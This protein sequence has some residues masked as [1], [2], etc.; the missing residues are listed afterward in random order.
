[1]KKTDSRSDVERLHSEAETE[2]KGGKQR[3]SLK[4]RLLI[5]LAAVVLIPSGLILYNE[6]LPLQLDG[7]KEITIQV[8]EKYKDPGVRSGFVKTYGSVDTGKAGD[9][10]ITYKRGGDSVK[11]IVHVIDEAADADDARAVIGLKGSA[12]TLVKEGDPYI[13]SGAF[14][15]DRENGAVDS[16][17]VKCKSNVDT[18]T[19][20]TYKVTYTGKTGDVRK[21]AERT[22]KVLPADQFESN[23]AGVPVLM[24]HYIYTE[25]DVPSPLN[26]NYTIDTKFEEQLKY[27]TENEYYYPSFAELRAYVDGKIDLP[28]KSVILTFDDGQ[29]GFLK[30][31]IPLLEKY[32]VPAV[33]FV[34]GTEGAAEKVR[35]YPSRYIQFQSHSHDMHKA[36]GNIGHGGVISALS[37]EQIVSDLQQ[38]FKETGNQ[39]AFAY[40]YGDVTDTARQ[41]IADSGLDCAFTT[42]YG[43]VRKGEDFRSLSRVRVSGDQS[44]ASYAAQLS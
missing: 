8:G 36:G 11:R 23:T 33:S 24:Y 14:L 16:A 34:I 31:G 25:T 4:W 22:V 7:K 3:F 2:K 35:T 40:P 27:L 41:A 29:E 37:G 19:P 28:A 9:Y 38:S 5:L 18:S 39:D 12:V 44:L 30:Y 13:E 1:M 43:K 17:S 26:V 21:T 32:Q 15:I 42:A 6:L 20:G 10:T